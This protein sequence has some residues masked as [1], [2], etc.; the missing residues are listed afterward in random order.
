MKN[1]KHILVKDQ[2][3]DNKYKV[4][5]FLKKGSYAESYRVKSKSGRNLFLK[6]LFYHKLQRSQ[7]TD[8]DNILE[9][10][11]LKKIKHPNIVRYY[12]SG[13]FILNNQKL[14]YL[15]LD[16]ISGETLA[17]RMRREQ[18]FNPYV[19]KEIVLGVLN[20]LNYLHN[21][22]KTVI[23]N[24]ITNLNVMLDLSGQLPIPKIID[25]GE[26][27]Y[28]EQS[29][30]DFSKNDLNPFYMAN[31]AFNKIFSPQSDIFSVGALY[32]HLLVGLPPWFIDL[33][34]YKSD[35]EKMEEAV[36]REREK[37]IQMVSTN[38]KVEDETFDII[39]KAL[40]PNAENRFRSVQE[41]IQAINGEIKVENTR[42]ST[43]LSNL[44]PT[45]KVKKGRGFSAIAGMQQLK[46]QMQLDVIDALNNKEKYA[47]YGLTIPNGMLLYGPPGCGK[48]FF[49]EKLSEEIGFTF[50]QIKPSD[51]QSK[52]INASQEN[53]KQL[54]ED[55]KNN[56][57]SII[58]IDEL[59]AIVPDRN[60][61]NINHM[62]TSVVNE[63]LA[64]MNNCGDNDIFIIGATNR[65]T[66]IDPAILRSGRLDKHVY[67]SPPD[68]DARKAMF[69]LYLEKRPI[70]LGLNYDNLATQTNNYASS[71]IRLICDE[72]ARIA[73]KSNSRITES[74]LFSVIKKS[75]P[76]FNTARL[77]EYENIR[78]KMEG[79]EIKDNRPRVGFK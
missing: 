18:S 1:I 69:K 55:A 63:L 74:I 39:I 3:L 30:K 57:P 77:A 40:Q 49:A 61:P 38:L 6:L 78:L 32:Y 47:E 26:A 73:L 51:I 22:E 27:R 2:L 60:S 50:Y 46:D 54:F 28:F 68:Y 7:F 5:F 59:D 15:V 9:T 29:S 67:I 52:W 11:I 58:F 45:K 66:A 35:K 72:A 34:K 17:E 13:E 53:V 31:E 23:H 71:D 65:P 70:E 10:E 20:G 43:R 48:T 33:S 25:F 16:F 14:G 56:S 75:I 76:S 12:D 62:N 41:F 79:K 64:Q 42:Q 37:P 36:L 4:S 8:E 24:N 19:A 21:L 44:K